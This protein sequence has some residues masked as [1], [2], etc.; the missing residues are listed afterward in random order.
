M[1]L[2]IDDDR[3]SS[4]QTMHT[5]RPAPGREHAWE[6]SWLP[7]QLL[8]RNTAI[9]AMTLADMASPGNLHTRQ[10]LW[11]HIESWAA[12][13]G[14]TAPDA[15]AQA[16]QPPGSISAEKTPAVPADPEAAGS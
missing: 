16:S 14:L 10:Q 3:I 11:P 13:L 1:T 8:G 12:E 2:I 15:L 9:T 5:A 7:G 4:D 6:V